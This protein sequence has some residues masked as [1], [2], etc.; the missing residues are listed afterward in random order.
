MGAQEAARSPRYHRIVAIPVPNN[1]FAKK[2]DLSVTAL[3]PSTRKPGYVAV[4]VGRR[5]V[6]TVT[7]AQARDLGLAVGQAWNALLQQRVAQAAAQADIQRHA[8]TLLNR[9]AMSVRELSR[10]LT[11]RGLGA[12]AVEG[13]VAHLVEIGALN[14]EAFARAL[15]E[16]TVA[17]KPAGP[18]LLRAKL[19]QRGV[20]AALIERL[21][22]ELSAPTEILPQA[23]ALARKRQASLAHLDRTTQ[24]RRLWALLARRGFDPDTIEQ[25]LDQL[26]LPGRLD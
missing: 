8:M 14:D 1:H 3:A 6:A 7:A 26:A 9:R 11:S 10:K 18:R 2:R 5:I 19:R 16:E 4:K 13:V 23:L 25:A 15:I 21:L 22:T 20:N 24:K 17:R 12:S